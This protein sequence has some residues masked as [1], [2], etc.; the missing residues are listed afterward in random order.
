MF[1]ALA[2]LGSMF[3]ESGL[4]SSAVEC[5]HLCLQLEPNHAMVQ[6]ALGMELLKLQLNNDAVTTLRKAV[7]QDPNNGEAVF[8]LYKTLFQQ[9]RAEALS[10]PA[11]Q[12]AVEQLKG[13]VV[14][15]QSA[16]FGSGASPSAVHPILSPAYHLLVKAMESA[17]QRAEAVA[18]AEEWTLYCPTEAVAHF[19][20]GRLLLAESRSQ[21]AEAALLR[22]QR[23]DSSKAQTA[24]QLALAEYKQRH[25]TQ[26]AERVK[27]AYLVAQ[28]HDPALHRLLTQAA[29]ADTAPSSSA[30]PPS[31]SA[32]PPLP[33]AS[34]SVLCQL[35]LLQ[36]KVAFAQ[37]SHAAA[38]IPLQRYLTYRPDDV[39]A[40]RLY[41]LCMQAEGKQTE[42]YAAFA[43]MMR[44]LAVEGGTS[45]GSETARDSAT[46][47]AALLTAG[48]NAASGSASGGKSKD[49]TKSTA[50]L[51][52]RR[53]HVAAVVDSIG[54][55]CRQPV[56]AEQ[57]PAD[58]KDAFENMCNQHRQLQLVVGSGKKHKS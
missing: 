32:A 54:A 27:Q 39:S 52:A 47:A 34:E 31:R 40:L 53:R 41:A 43:R 24:Y 42:A 25:F 35:D 50:A 11:L 26:A 14:A 37:S 15:L 36:A 29:V 20:H 19:T 23:L 22:A 33:A 6:T 57:Q 21:E 12:Q 16:P 13:A 2:N 3:A 48:G 55:A 8:H 28:Q 38:V 4:S 49:S 18:V 44:A 51:L 58:V 1:N 45:E 9:Q 5:F 30:Q 56:S 10:G 46:T 17:G 7:R